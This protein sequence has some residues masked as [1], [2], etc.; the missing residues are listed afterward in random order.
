MATVYDCFKKAC[1]CFAFNFVSKRGI[2]ATLATASRP[3]SVKWATLENVLG[4]PVQNF[5]Y[6]Y[7]YILLF[8]IISQ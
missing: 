7:K 3:G 2:A 4:T 1:N 6:I 5:L 8:F